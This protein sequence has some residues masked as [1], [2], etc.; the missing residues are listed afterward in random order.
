MHLDLAYQVNEHVDKGTHKYLINITKA[1]NAGQE[2][3]RVCNKIKNLGFKPDVIYAHP[4]WGDALFVKDIFPD[5]P[6]L[7]Y[8][9][10]YYQP[11]GA[12]M[13][14]DPEDKVEPDNLA[15]LRLKNV[16][17]LLNLTACD[18][19]ISPTIWQKKQTPIEF[20]NKISVLHEGID[21]DHITV[22]DIDK[23][24]INKNLTFHKG[25]QIITYIARNFEPYRGFPTAMRAF[26]ILQKAL[27]DAHI[28]LIGSDG[29]SYGKSAK[30]FKTYKEQMLDELNFDMSRLHFV[31][32]LPYQKMLDLLQISNA[33]IYLTYPFVLSWSMLESMASGCAMICSKTAPVEEV[34]ID[35][36]N[37]HFVDFFSPEDVAE[38]VIKVVNDRD[39]NKYIRENA[40]KTILDRFALKKLLPLH[41]QLLNDV[42]VGAFPPPADDNI[43]QHHQNNIPEIKEEIM[44]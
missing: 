19:A 33:H 9:E 18:W 40:R 17:H 31:G 43:M 13:H 42:A 26:H 35:G 6:L 37:G 3:W 5:A 8:S 23:V 10:F 25:Q 7:N 32:K 38:K 29:V 16:N 27:P 11:F 44:V 2:V 4:G 20:H 1:V 14:F 28:I 21:T 34:I 41:L 36:Y 24:V 22:K 15:R 30:N 12:D 39:G